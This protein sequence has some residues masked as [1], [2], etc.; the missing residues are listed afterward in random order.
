MV[1]AAN[2]DGVNDDYFYEDDA[3]CYDER[4]YVQE[5]Q[6]SMILQTNGVKAK[7]SGNSAK[8]NQSR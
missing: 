3:Q 4:Q 2:D 6:S 8:L 7:N 1:L 5:S